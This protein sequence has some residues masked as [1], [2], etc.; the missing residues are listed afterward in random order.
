MLPTRSLLLN[1]QVFQRAGVA[2]AGIPQRDPEALSKG[3]AIVRKVLEDNK[4]DN[5]R[6]WKTSELYALAL[7]E[8]APEGF[9]HNVVRNGAPLP[10]HLDHPIRSKKCVLGA[11]ARCIRH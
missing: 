10:P 11:M 6:G 8:K 3:I 7:K 4:K 5:A 2:A 9:T 1:L